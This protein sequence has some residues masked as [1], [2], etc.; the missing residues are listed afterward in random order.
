MRLAQDYM[1][2]YRGYHTP[3]GLCRARIYYPES[4]GEDSPSAIAVLSEIPENE[5]TSITNLAETLFCELSLDRGLPEGTWFIEH[6]PRDEN[7]RRAGLAEEIDVVSFGPLNGQPD[8]EAAG[9][10]YVLRAL[11]GLSRPTFG[12]AGWEPIERD[13][14]EWNLGAGFQWEPLPD[15]PSAYSSRIETERQRSADE[16]NARAVVEE[17]ALPERPA[18]E[19][20]F[21]EGSE[22]LVIRRAEE[23]DNPRA[24]ALETNVV[25]SVIHHSPTGFETGYGGSGPADL[26]LNVLSA[27]IPPGEDDRSAVRCFRGQCSHSAWVLHQSFKEAFLTGMDERGESIPA[28]I[29]RDWLEDHTDKEATT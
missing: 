21:A 25:R 27:L 26:A 1:M 8:G 14:L 6:Y 10:P 24:A 28:R 18:I 2:P 20:A 3:G 4:A 12:P 5:N 15:K 17:A 29:I 9:L 22:Y 11:G 23:M 19:P 13:M 7:Q 16:S